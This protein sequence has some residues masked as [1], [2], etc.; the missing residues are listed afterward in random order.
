MKSVSV[1]FSAKSLLNLVVLSVVGVMTFASIQ[2]Q[3][4]E[5]FE[6]TGKITETAKVEVNGSSTDAISASSLK[7]SEESGVEQAPPSQPTNIVKNVAVAVTSL[8]T[9][10]ILEVYQG[11]TK[12][13]TVELTS[14]HF[15]LQ[16]YSSAPVLLASNSDQ[17]VTADY[18]I[19]VT[20]RPDKFVHTKYYVSSQ[21]KISTA[22]KNADVTAGE[23]TAAADKEKP[24]VVQN[25]KETVY[26]GPNQ[27]LQSDRDPL[28]IVESEVNNITIGDAAVDASYAINCRKTNAPIEPGYKNRSNDD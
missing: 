26:Y 28:L 19:T 24:P 25:S 21:L 8:S 2:A 18:K 23:T 20:L 12:E 22:P 6:C 7:I 13:E 17:D 4:E 15:Q 5:R 27:E 16:G 11:N 1:C 10:L 9:P 14:K 3:A